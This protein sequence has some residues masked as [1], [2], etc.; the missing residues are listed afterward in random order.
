M[1]CTTC[2][3]VLR[4]MITPIVL[5]S[6]VSAIKHYCVTCPFCIMSC[7]VFVAVEASLE[8]LC[9][10]T[11]GIEQLLVSPVGG[12]FTLGSGDATL[13]FPPGAIMKETFIRYA[14]IVHGPFVLPAA[15]ELASVV[16]YIN[17]D[18]ATLVKPVLLYL[19][20]W[21]IKKEGDDDESLRFA[22]A[23]HSLPIGQQ[24][25]KFEEQE[26]ADFITHT[27]V[28]ILKISEPQC[29]HCVK[30]CMRTKRGKYRAVSFSKDID[31]LPHHIH[32][33]PHHIH[34]H[35]LFR[36]HVMCDS[37]EWDKVG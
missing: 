13:E 31:P 34:P 37:E 22:T 32:P 33:L 9:Y 7:F 19:S 17:M 30:W 26:E 10:I 28:G 8:K 29:L 23:P 20:H 5:K 12:K 11:T 18:G 4:N 2:L 1:I 35:Q 3:I 36:I 16:V 15:C 21:C 24:C 14:I 6:K 25:Y 27:N